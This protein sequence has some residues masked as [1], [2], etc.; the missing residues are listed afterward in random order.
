MGKHHEDDCRHGGDCRDDDHL[1][2]IVKKA[3]D[4]DKV[5]ALVRD[6]Q[7]FCMKCGRSRTAPTTSAPRSRSS[8]R[9]LRRAPVRRR[10][11]PPGRKN[12]PQSGRYQRQAV[13]SGLS[14][15]CSCAYRRHAI[16]SFRNR[17]FACAPRDTQPRHA[18]DHV[19]REAEA[20]DLIVHRQL[21]RRVDVSPSPCKP[22]T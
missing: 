7:Y 21:Q 10:A 17:S 12:A 3:H 18:V 5:H 11:T 14:I 20:V 19:D 6:A 1:C 13:T 9:P 4:M 22:R 15:P 8:R 2:R 16:C